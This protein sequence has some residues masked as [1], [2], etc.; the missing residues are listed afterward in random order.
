MSVVIERFLAQ[1]YEMH[2]VDATFIGV[3]EHDARLPDWGRFGRQ[4]AQHEMQHLRREIEAAHPLPLRADGHPDWAAL[5][6]SATLLDAEL[7]RANLDVRILELESF[8]FRDLNPALWSGEAVFSAVALL[9]RTFA[10]VGERAVVLGERMLD[11]RRFL[12]QMIGTLGGPTPAPWL[13]RARREFRAG[14]RLLGEDV[15]LWLAKQRVH[16]PD[17]LETGR[18]A[19]HAAEVLASL[20]QQMEFWSKEQKEEQEKGETPAPR[21]AIGEDD[22]TTLLRRGHFVLDRPSTLLARAERD[23]DDARRRLDEI[24]R[25][26]AGSSEALAAMLAADQPIA[27]NFL[28]AFEARWDDCRTLGRVHDLVTWPDEWP[29]RYVPQPEWAWSSAPDLYFLPYRAPSP[30]DEYR[31][32]DYLVAPLARDVEPD[33]RA[34]TLAAW[35]R[36][37]ITLNHVV[38]HGGMGHHVQN[39]HAARGTRSAIGRIAAVDGASRIAMLLGGS[40]AEGWACYATDLAEEFGMLTPLERAAEQQSR[41]RQLARAVL[42]IRLHCGERSFDDSVTFMRDTLGLPEAAA[43]SEVTKASMLPATPIMYWIGTQGIHDLRA[44]V[45]RRE[46]AAFS[47]KRFHDTLLSWGSIPVPLVSKLMLEG[48]PE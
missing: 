3:H 22:Y 27:E 45:Q 10:P 16:F 8:Y 5:A 4:D 31:G 26:V 7:A 38:H 15:P 39:W 9:L 29:L 30:F 44:A 32:H 35:N 41:V 43:L 42:D 19:E 2:P 48:R 6:G 13:A 36:S 11:L 28:D 21:T 33:A 24:T 34:R 25:E 17:H 20:A 12:G 23:L 46:G 18:N 37:Q 1:F 14:A 47:L 40:M